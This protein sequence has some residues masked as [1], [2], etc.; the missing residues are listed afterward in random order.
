M[1]GERTGGL[2]PE[3]DE[4][5][6]LQKAALEHGVEIHQEAV[7]AAVGEAFLLLPALQ[8]GP[9]APPFR[10]RLPRETGG[11]EDIPL[12]QMD[13]VKLLGGLPEAP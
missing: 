10:R 6:S 11:V 9:A 13:A 2:L 5:A 8:G 1:P 3:V 7:L 4:V 12:L